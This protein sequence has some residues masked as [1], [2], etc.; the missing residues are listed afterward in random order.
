MKKSSKAD[1][2]FREPPNI[3][4]SGNCPF[5]AS[6]LG[7]QVVLRGREPQIEN[8]LP[9]KSFGLS[10]QLRP[11]GVVLSVQMDKMAKPAGGPNGGALRAPQR[12]LWRNLSFFFLQ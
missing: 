9:K 5:C 2:A 7:S 3:E 11:L 4:G 8:K 1:S 10:R 12:I 6:K